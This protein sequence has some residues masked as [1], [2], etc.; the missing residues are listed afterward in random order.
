MKYTLSIAFCLLMSHTVFAEQPLQRIAMSKP[1]NTDQ[2]RS[3]T[4]D[5]SLDRLAVNDSIV[6]QNAGINYSPVQPAYQTQS[7]RNKVGLFQGQL[8]RAE[9][10][11]QTGEIT[12]S[13]LVKTTN[14]RALLQVSAQAMAIGQNYVLLTFD[15]NTELLAELKRLQERADV[16]SAELEVNTKRRQPR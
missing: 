14:Q 13:I 6:V 5:Q 12:G 8:M 15:S 16:E 4:H 9:H 7:S 2:T 10:S 11:R 1:M 3:A